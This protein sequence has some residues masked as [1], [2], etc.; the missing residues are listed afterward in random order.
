VG[1]G[2]AEERVQRRLAAILAADVVGYSRLMDSDE[3]G[4]LAR[5]K[6]IRAEVLDPKIE[7]FRGRVF[8]N[9]GDGA[10]AEFAS[11]VDAV[12]C[13]VDIQ[14]S[15]A[16]QQAGTSDDRSLVIRIGIS[17]GDVIV[18]GDDLFGNGVNVAARMEGL[19]EPGGICISG[20]VR[21]HVGNTL[22]VT[23][24]DI[25]DQ[26]VKNI[27]RP[28]RCYRVNLGS[29]G[30]AS[31]QSPRL[32]DKPS[33][34]VLPFDSMSGDPDQE[35]FSDGISEDIITA[36]SR[37]R[38]LR[39]LAR[40]SSFSYKGQNTD[41]REVAKELEVRYLLEGSVRR[42]ANR[43]RVSAQLIDGASGDHI[44][45]ER[46]DRELE[47]I[48]AVQDEIT[49]TVTASIEPEL[50][51]AERRR[52]SIK[53]PTSMDAWDLYH[54]AMTY[55]YVRD[56][57]ECK[58]AVG[59]LEQSVALDPQFC[60]AWAALTE[61]LFNVILLGYSDDKDS[62]GM[63][64]YEAAENAVRTDNDD[65]FAHEALGR[66]NLWRRRYAEA[67]AEYRKAV[68]LNPASAKGHYGYGVALVHSGNAAG[69]V[70]QFAEAIR[71]S[72]KDPFRNAYYSRM[73][74]G[75][76]QLDQYDEAIEWARKALAEPFS[77]N[78]VYF[79]LISALGHA[80]RQEEAGQVLEELRVK[81]P[82][83][84]VSYV[85]NLIPSVPEYLEKLLDGLRKAKLPE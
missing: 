71:L 28:V 72:P 81:L 75:Q 68:S 37:F 53:P 45:A 78:M 15:L 30:T 52:V 63:R 83:A 43:I 16:A 36:L 17:Q 38:W 62:D 27:D 39:V 80:G 50:A 4:T 59:L 5:L 6:S 44:W 56:S 69:A 79:F 47:D 46:Y 10:M 58:K 26:I 42:S 1:G 3:A 61:A 34:A 41:L 73:A 20:N 85:R 25:G 12:Q 82:N 74:L 11:S 51:G 2:V 64:M 60:R 23:L 84:S 40:N 7:D 57:D 76:L 77:E 14:N 35:Y 19:A 29:K 31:E 33:I 9:T 21:E 54:Q 48:F 22:D 55:Y 49:E 65:H 66:A 70:E 67:I 32:P 24:E 8:K 13:A 18:D